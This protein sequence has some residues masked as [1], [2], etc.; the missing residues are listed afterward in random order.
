MKRKEELINTW[1][2]TSGLASRGSHLLAEGRSS[3]AAIC[4]LFSLTDQKKHRI[5]N[6]V[7]ST[8][9]L[10][11]LYRF[12]VRF[13]SAQIFLL[14]QKYPDFIYEWLEANANRQDT[15]VRV[16]TE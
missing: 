16:F 10:F 3:A 8:F 2:I 15:G 13:I 5:Q 14:W 6:N 1:F 12:R 7:V 9:S 11:L 4:F